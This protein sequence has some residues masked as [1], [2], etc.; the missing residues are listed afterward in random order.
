MTGKRDSKS[1]KILDD[2]ISLTRAEVYSTSSARP[3]LPYTSFDPSKYHL[4][5]LGSGSSTYDT[6]AI[7]DTTWDK[8]YINKRGLSKN[9]KN[10]KDIIKHEEA[11]RVVSALG[12]GINDV[13]RDHNNAWLLVYQSIGGKLPQTYY[14]CRHCHSEYMLD[15]SFFN[16]KHKCSCN[17]RVDVR[18]LIMINK[19][20]V[21]S[22]RKTSI[23][24]EAVSYA[25]RYGKQLTLAEPN[26]RFTVI[27]RDKDYS[28]KLNRSM[29]NGQK[30]RNYEPFLK[31]VLKKEKY[32]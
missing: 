15:F 12:I 9:R 3:F 18:G 28:V 11:H 26:D 17:T 20:Y 1:R 14:A 2:I 31:Y 5:D 22:K 32:L 7:Y 8:L 27:R 13:K 19:N 30:M 4:K 23:M 16:G 29:I 25:R 10:L 6:T 21:D 24:E